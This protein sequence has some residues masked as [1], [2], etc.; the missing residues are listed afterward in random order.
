MA[1]AA[2]H[3][4]PPPRPTTCRGRWRVRP[5]TR[6]LGYFPMEGGTQI[7]D[8]PQLN[9]PAETAAH[10]ALLGRGSQ[11]SQSR[12]RAGRGLCPRPNGRAAAASAGGRGAGEGRDAAGRPG[13]APLR[14][15]AK[16][17]ENFVMCDFGPCCQVSVD[18][19]S[20][21]IV[22]QTPSNQRKRDA[23]VRWQER[24]GKTT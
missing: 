7:R 14:A 18:M 11:V 10:K 19:T 16:P 12:R 6:P 15:K 8:A 17:S 4:V 9:V 24:R 5:T 13:G 22:C 21:F 20:S 2:R 1:S 23:I 3:L